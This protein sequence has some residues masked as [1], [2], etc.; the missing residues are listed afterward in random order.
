[1]PMAAQAKINLAARLDKF[2]AVTGALF[3]SAL[4]LG[5][6]AFEATLV[7]VGLGWMCRLI[8]LKKNPLPQIIRHPLLLPWL[9]WYATIVVSLLVNGPG[10]KGW[11][12]DIVFIRHFL[13]AAALLDISRRLPVEKYLLY[14]LAG[15]VLWVAMNLLSVYI[16]GFDIRGKTLEMYQTKLNMTGR[17]AGLAAYAGPF[18]IGWGIL[19]EKL[20]AK[21]KF[22]LIG[23]GMIA[24]GLV[25]HTTIR[26]AILAA[27][28]G[29]CFC[30]ISLL[31]KRFS[32]RMTT[33]ISFFTLFVGLGIC[34]IF[35]DKISF[36]TMYDRY[37]IWK[38]VCSIWREN[39]IF[40]VGISSF[41]N[42][43]LEAA[44]L[45]EPHM[46]LP[47]GGVYEYSIGATHA[48]NLLL[49][50]LACTGI[51]GLAAF[52]WLIINVLRKII[53]DHSGWR[54]GLTTW[55]IV[56]TV[57]GLSGFNIYH[58]WYLALFAF[59]IALIG[60]SKKNNL[61]SDH[62][63]LAF[64]YEGKKGDS[65]KINSLIC[66]FAVFHVISTDTKC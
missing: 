61:K 33:I 17:I 30:L 28:I 47:G 13:F 51:L 23:T 9:V 1:M 16:V 15:G 36:L 50:I 55:P 56:L 63:G 60:C 21:G 6:T 42:V 35:W 31:S 3:P 10:H 18:F 20:S 37:H 39:P 8:L 26:T 29:I 41:Q 27:L 44:Q 34:Y 5:N 66:F 46:V 45:F 25:L 40:G 11:L 64:L 54:T 49:M 65:K 53:L 7:L 19:A 14:G 52:L 2:C 32:F 58:S 12:H 62:Q 22:F 59:F 43:Y 24:L 48:H 4:I 57:D 38:V